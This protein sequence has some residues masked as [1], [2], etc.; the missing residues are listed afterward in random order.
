V[1][2]VLRKAG[3]VEDSLGDTESN[4]MERFSGVLVMSSLVQ[5]YMNTTL[6]VK[7]DW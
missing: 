3:R 2:H 4:T 1:L 5:P 7:D 6:A